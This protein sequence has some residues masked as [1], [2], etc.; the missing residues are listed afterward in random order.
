MILATKFGILREPNNP[1]FRGLDGRPEYMHKAFEASLKRL[2]VRLRGSL[3]PTPRRSKSAH[4][5]NRRRDGRIGQSRQSAVFG[6]ERSFAGYLAP[7][8]KVH[9]ITAL[10]SEYSL[11]TC[12][13]EAEVIPA[14]RSLGIGFVPYSPLGRGFLSGSIVK[15]D[16]LRPG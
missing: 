12:D 6:L 4:R 1:S 11:W 7:R 15:P 10:Q 5:E 2:G 9:P 13:P 8:D 16:D 3:L 14:C